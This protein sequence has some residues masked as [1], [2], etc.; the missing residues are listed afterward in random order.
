METDNTPPGWSRWDTMVHSMRAE[1][2]LAAQ[3]MRH[4]GRDGSEGWPSYWRRN[5]IG[6]RA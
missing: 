1:A 2:R 4:L 6:G 5:P 3:D